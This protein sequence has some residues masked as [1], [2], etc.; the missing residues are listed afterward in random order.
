M[1]THWMQ[2]HRRWCT[3]NPDASRRSR[4]EFHGVL[5][6]V[7]KNKYRFF[8]SFGA[9]AATTTHFLHSRWIWNEKIDSKWTK[10]HSRLAWSVGGSMSG[11]MDGAD[12]RISAIQ[13]RKELCNTWREHLTSKINVVHR[14]AY[15]TSNIGAWKR[16]VRRFVYRL[17]GPKFV[18]DVMCRP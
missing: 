16:Q 18:S 17:I 11:W 12:E 1:N 10:C 14:A 3:D 6:A 13:Q 8:V 9:T 15:T 2:R 5:S 4:G 7:R